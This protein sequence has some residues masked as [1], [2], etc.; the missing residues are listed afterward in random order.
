MAITMT[1]KPDLVLVTQTDAH[2][3]VVYGIEWGMEWKD[4]ENHGEDFSTENRGHTILNVSDITDFVAIED[5]T[6]ATLKQW[7]IDSIDAAQG[8]STFV[9]HHEQNFNETAAEPRTTIYWQRSDSDD[10]AG[11]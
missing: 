6:H 2:S 1:F 7:V 4:V 11:V 10:P 9:E 3:D 5:V 8:W